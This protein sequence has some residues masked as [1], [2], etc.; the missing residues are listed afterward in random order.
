MKLVSLERELKILLE[1]G[2]F[3]LFSLTVHLFSEPELFKMR[4][5]FFTSL[6]YVNSEAPNS[7]PRRASAK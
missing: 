4:S 1:L 5:I 3:A 2:F 6:Y 7:A